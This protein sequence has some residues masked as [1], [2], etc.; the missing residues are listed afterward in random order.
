MHFE[1]PIGL[2]LAL[3]VF[4]LLGCES[5]GG[6][7][8]QTDAPA[9]ADLERLAIWM[10]GSFTSEA[11]AAS[12]DQYFDIRLEMARIWP[13]LGTDQAWLYVEQATASSLD[14][15]YRQR[16]YRLTRIDESRFES[17]VFELPPDP[18]AFAGWWRTPSLFARLTPNDLT[19]LPGCS[20][21]LEYDHSSQRFVGATDRGTCVSTLRGA[22]YVVSEVTIT[23]NLLL[24]WDRGFDSDDQQVWGAVD[25][26]YEFVRVD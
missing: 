3:S 4:V 19:K 10:V 14:R 15:P 7:V 22:A 1:R 20:V 5:G 11:Q 26:G 2:I 18:L 17:A 8:R 25:G 9:D 16:I 24:T 6:A 13:E 21:Y 12:D 23:P